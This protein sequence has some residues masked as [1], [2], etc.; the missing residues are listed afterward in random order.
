RRACQGLTSRR[1]WCRRIF[2]SSRTVTAESPLCRRASHGRAGRNR[3]EAGRLAPA[4]SGLRD[5]DLDPGTLR[6]RL[7]DGV[8]NHLGVETVEE[9]GDG[10]T[11]FDDRRDELPHQVV[12]KHGGRRALVRIARAVG[13]LEELGGD[14]YRR[15]VLAGLAE[16][17]RVRLVQPVDR[18]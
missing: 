1:F 12:A 18:R 16:E 13:W 9:A 8:G 14:C 6:V 7:E 17:D 5:R 3:L 2:G 15:Q 11:T 4:S 10:G